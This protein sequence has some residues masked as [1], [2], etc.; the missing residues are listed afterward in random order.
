MQPFEEAYRE[1]QKQ[2][3][4]HEKS[5]K[6]VLE[7]KLKADEYLDVAREH[8]EELDIEIETSRMNVETCATMRRQQED[9]LRQMN[10]NL[11]RLDERYQA[12]LVQVPE[13]Q[14]QLK[15]ASREYDAASDAVNSINERQN[16]LRFS[17]RAPEQAIQD[18]QSELNKIKDS[19][20]A[21]CNKLHGQTSKDVRQAMEWIQ[22]NK[23]RFKG[24]CYGPVGAEVEVKTA[25]DAAMLESVVSYQKLV[26]FLVDTK[27]DEQLLNKELRGRLRLSINI[28]TM[29]N[30]TFA[31]QPL[32]REYLQRARE[33]YGFEGFLGD[34]CKCGSVFEI[35]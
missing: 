25:A 35:V 7:K 26:T 20:A 15:V 34:K 6:S 9:N 22:H 29:Y 1:L 17:L 32:P 14:E 12:V 10:E 18:I 16:N 8:V 2:Q 19:R 11:Q 30:K 13:V 5:T 4:A 28:T 27:E 23:D 24:E 33:S 3:M 31:P 21:F